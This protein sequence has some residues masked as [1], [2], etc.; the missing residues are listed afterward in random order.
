[1]LV[2]GPDG[3]TVEGFQVHLGGAL[4]EEAG[5]GRKLRAMKI[6]ANDAADYVERVVTHFT[7]QQEPGESFAGWV[8]RA[9]EADLR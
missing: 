9:D 1:M 3:E 4:G 7:E 8:L 5:F 2:P 6:T